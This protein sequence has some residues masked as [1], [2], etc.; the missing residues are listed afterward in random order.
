VNDTD[1][2]T[3]LRELAQLEESGEGVPPATGRLASYRAGTLPAEEAERLEELLAGDV[4][5][6][7]RLAALAGVMLP[8][9]PD[10]VRA[11]VLA[12]AGR[13]L[14][15]GR[16]RGRGPGRGWVWAA[17]AG[18][19][20]AA[21]AL[22]FYLRRPPSGGWPAGRALPVYEVAVT[23]LAGV[24]SLPGA[25]A[26]P[27]DHAEALPETRVSITVAPADRAVAGVDFGLYRLAG[28]RLE[29]ISAGVEGAAGAP[30]ATGPAIHQVSGRGAASFDALAADLVGRSPGAHALFLVV[31]PRGELPPGRQLAPGEDPA[32]ALAAAGRHRVYPLRITLRAPA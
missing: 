14:S 2:E 19:V 11:E 12:S 29:R 24:R 16:S 21:A 20:L 17:A 31:A 9:P 13:E 4:A 26:T 8:R 1:S 30:G 23:G 18:L 15:K 27:Q 28:D 10:R 32:R 6:R 7:E 22:V 3:L 25:E 5:A